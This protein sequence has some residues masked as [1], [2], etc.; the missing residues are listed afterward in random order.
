[1]NEKQFINLLEKYGAIIGDDCFVING[2]KEDYLVTSDIMTESTHFEEWIDPYSLGWKIA[3][4]NLSDI[5]A[6]GGI[7]L[8]VF[9][10]IAVKS[11][12][13]QWSNQFLSGLTDLINKFSV[14]LAGGDTVRSQNTTVAITAIGKLPHNSAVLR[15]GAKEGDLLVVSGFTGL[16]AYGL[17]C[18]RDG[19]DDFAE[20]QLKPYPEIELGLKLREL[21]IPTAMIDLSDGIYQDACKLAES[22][23]CAMIIDAD[24]LIHS[25]PLMKF[26][27]TDLSIKYALTG[28]EDYK[29]LFTIKKENKNMLK[30]LKQLSPDIRIIGYVGKGEGI[31]VIHKGQP[32]SIKKAGFMHFELS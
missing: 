28:G 20:F 25:H 23:K 32:I 4:V 14:K 13:D 27:D 10:D 18:V 30:E 17:N 3:A 22:S 24:S 2:A 29:L 6:M 12:D 5:A 1:M 11:L 9:L 16:A 15:S 7:P 26:L 21:L 31:T 19:T 8:F